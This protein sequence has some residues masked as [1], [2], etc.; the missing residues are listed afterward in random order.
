MPA[1]RFG[2]EGKWRGE[3]GVKRGENVAPFP[4]EEGS[5][6]RRRCPV[7]LSEEEDGRSAD[8][9]GPPISEGEVVG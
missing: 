1:V 4:L 9:V 5:S 3:W 2:G 7:G 8:R 6:G